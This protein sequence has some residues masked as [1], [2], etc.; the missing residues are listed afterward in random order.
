M[1]EATVSRLQNR[2]TAP[3]KLAGS[4][5]HAEYDLNTPLMVTLQSAA[6]KGGASLG[7]RAYV[8]GS[9]I[10]GGVSAAGMW[11]ISALGEGIGPK[12]HTVYGG[13]DSI[14]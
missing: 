7:F 9:G 10:E 12:V 2:C 8:N 13:G 6:C 3:E 11:S 5:E 1:T 4:V 14:I